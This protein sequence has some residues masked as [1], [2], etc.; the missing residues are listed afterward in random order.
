MVADEEAELTLRLGL[1]F[2]GRR[3][4]IRAVGN[5]D[6]RR[7]EIADPAVL[8]FYARSLDKSL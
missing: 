2:L 4:A 6:G 3:K 5:G 7:I 8:R 1:E